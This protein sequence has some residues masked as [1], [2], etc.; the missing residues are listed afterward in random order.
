MLVALRVLTQTV[1]EALYTQ[2]GVAEGQSAVDKTKARGIVGLVRDALLVTH[3]DNEQALE[4]YGFAV[5]IGTA[6]VGRKKSTPPTT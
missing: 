2:L 4:G 6:A 3:A 1:S 5:T